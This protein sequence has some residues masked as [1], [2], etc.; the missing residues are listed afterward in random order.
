MVLAMLGDGRLHLSGIAKLAAHLTEANRDAVLARATHR[1]R[2]EIEDLVAELAPRPDVPPSIRR[3]PERGREATPP[4]TGQAGFPDSSFDAGQEPPLEGGLGPA[5]PPELGLDRATPARAPERAAPIQPLSPAR[6]K[7]QFTASASF[8]EKLERLTSLMRS[9]VPDGDLARI[10]E[11]AVTEKLARLERR[12]FGRTSRPAKGPA[13]TD[14]PPWSRGGRHTVHN[15]RVMC[16]THNI[17]LA[18]R[19]FGKELMARYRRR[20]EP[21]GRSGR[22]ATLARGQGRSG[23]QSERRASPQS[24]GRTGTQSESRAS[25][26]SEGRRSLQSQPP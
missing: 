10:V 17:A 12:R 8:C 5:F 6:Y 3:L 1:S 24:E 19:D 23:S 4:P 25:A 14:D 22:T 13:R 16:R 9:S 11:Q 7:V 21:A 26:Q 20:I 2:R 18:E 15:I